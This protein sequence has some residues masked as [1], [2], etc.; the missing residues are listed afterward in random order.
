MDIYYPAPLGYVKDLSLLSGKRY[1]NYRL[2]HNLSDAIA[3]LT[4]IMSSA[5]KS[6]YPDG[7]S[8]LER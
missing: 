7:V 3:T 2:G 5:L 8:A 4:P 1:P 6:V